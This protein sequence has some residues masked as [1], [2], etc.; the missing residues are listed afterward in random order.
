MAKAEP[1]ACLVVWTRQGHISGYLFL[2]FDSLGG[3]E[4]G[5]GRG[6]QEERKMMEGGLGFVGGEGK[7]KWTYHE[8]ATADAMTVA[9]YTPP[10]FGKL[11][12]TP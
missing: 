8:P 9:A 3:G 5:E 4:E 11:Y 7:K 1:V 2:F 10:M 12:S 6:T